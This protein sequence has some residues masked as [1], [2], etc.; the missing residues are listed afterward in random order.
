MMLRHRQEPL[1]FILPQPL[2]PLPTPAPQSV[3]TATAIRLPASSMSTSVRRDPV[4]PISFSPAPTSG[5]PGYQRL[6]PN[7]DTLYMNMERHAATRGPAL[8]M[9]N[10][11]HASGNNNHNARTT[12]NSFHNGMARPSLPSFLPPPPDLVRRGSL[13]GQDHPHAYQLPPPLPTPTTAC[14]VRR[15]STTSPP[16]LRPGS[17]QA[18]YLGR[19]HQ[20]HQPPA[21]VVSFTGG[22]HNHTLIPPPPPPTTTTTSSSWPSGAPAP[23]FT[24]QVPRDVNNNNVPH[25]VGMAS[26]GGG[27]SSSSTFPGSPPRP[28]PRPGPRPAAVPALATSQRAPALDTKKQELESPLSLVRFQCDQ[29]LENFPTNGI[30]KRHKKTHSA[31][32]VRCAGCGAAYTDKS[33]LR[34]SLCPCLCLLQCPN[35]CLHVGTQ[36]G[37]KETHEEERIITNRRPQRAETPGQQ[38]LRP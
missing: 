8:P 25:E 37:G 26:G 20:P 9:M 22:S 36:E 18:N 1:P 6:D 33:A 21:P 35:G 4:L 11:C 16:V 38:G 30:L 23:T 3:A 10:T 27:A 31:K 19:P 7:N 5:A 29:C 24:G 17:Y 32:K 12:T 28:G 13:S 15:S 34:V 2:G 14:P